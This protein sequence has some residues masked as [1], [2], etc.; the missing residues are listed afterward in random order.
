MYKPRTKTN[1]LLAS[2]LALGLWLPSGLA[3]GQSLE[4]QSALKQYFDLNS[5]GR[6]QEALPFAEAILHLTYPRKSSAYR[7]PYMVPPCCRSS[8]EPRP[9]RRAVV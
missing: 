4:L 7:L 1:W 5:L 6:Y 9:G 2:L 3:Y 8:C